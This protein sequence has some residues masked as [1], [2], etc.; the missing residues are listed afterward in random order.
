MRA[1]QS[2]PNPLIQ[3]AVR[4]GADLCRVAIIG[5]VLGVS[6]GSVVG[7]SPL[8]PLDEPEFSDQQLTMDTLKTSL[9]DARRTIVELRAEVDSRRQE[10]ADLQIARAQ[11]E[12]R[13]R[14]AE[15]R[16]IEAR[17]VIDLQREELA[18]SRSARERAA[19]TGATLQSQLKQLHNQIA[20]MGSPAGTPSARGR[21]MGVAPAK[22]DQLD[23]L[24]ERAAVAVTQA[25]HLNEKASVDTTRISRAASGNPLRVVVMPGDTLWSIAQRH[26]VSLKRLMAMNQLSDNHIEVGQDLWLVYPPVSGAREYKSAE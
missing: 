25:P 3:G 24:Q 12:G 9:R 18:G 4:L 5:I 21:Q 23:V 8:E 17:H 14:E 1:Q 20:R 11:L 22:L 15:R 13:V 7:C 2:D 10:L 6:M 26:R 19:R 16:L